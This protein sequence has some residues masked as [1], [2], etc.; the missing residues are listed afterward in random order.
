MLSENTA[1]RYFGTESAIGKSLKVNDRYT[2]VV[3]GVFSDFPQQSHWH[4]EILLSFATLNDTTIYGR[5]GLETN[6]GNNSFGTYVLAKEPFD[7]SKTEK[8]FPAFV[9]RH[10]RRQ[11]ASNNEPMPSTW[12]N[13]FLQKLTDIHLHSHLDSEE[14]TNGNINNVYIMGVIGLVH[15]THCLFQFC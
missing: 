15:C 4:P 12:T 2:V 10:M 9:D 7:A 13:L 8:Q 6:W 3:S 11:E 1:K 5:K 14:E